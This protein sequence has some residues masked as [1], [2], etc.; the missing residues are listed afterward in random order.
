[1]S[2]EKLIQGGLIYEF[3]DISAGPRSSKF[4]FVLGAGLRKCP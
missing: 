3:E 1:M 4:C 2:L